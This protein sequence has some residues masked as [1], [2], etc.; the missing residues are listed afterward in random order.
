MI[1]FS[2]TTGIIEDEF[3]KIIDIYAIL[4]LH[5]FSTYG[6]SIAIDDLTQSVI[7]FK[8]GEEIDTD[9]NID[10]LRSI[11]NG[12]GINGG[13]AKNVALR[14]HRILKIRK[15]VT[16]NNNESLNILTELG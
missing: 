12:N 11:Y 10:K 13:S 9:K 2:Q 4:F 6:L 1:V 8:H 7:D 16:N 15:K 14:K 5:Y 3:S